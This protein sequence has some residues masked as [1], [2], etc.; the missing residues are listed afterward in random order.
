MKEKK[1]KTTRKNKNIS[2]EMLLFISSYHTWRMV[3]NN[4]YM[5]REV[6][7]FKCY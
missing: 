4:I 3:I 2:F 5:D 1:I 6:S 7:F